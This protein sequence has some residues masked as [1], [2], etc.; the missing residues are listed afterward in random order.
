MTVTPQNNFTGSVAL[1]VA[2]SPSTGLSA[3]L[4]SPS[5]AISGGAGT[6]TLTFTAQ[7]GGKYV[8]T[9]TATQGTL[10]H[11][12]NLT[13]T[14]NDFSMQVSPAKATVVRGK[15]VRFTVKLASAGAFNAAVKLSISGLPAR[16]TVIYV[17]NPTAATS[18]QTV[19]ITTSS[20]DGRGSLSLRFTGVSGILNHSVTVVLSVQ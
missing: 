1:A 13:V 18:S 3:D 9:V 4:S 11:T 6:S 8:V 19:T 14:V 12:A 5:I 7:K 17:H 10:V 15:K 20:K 16:D 2:V